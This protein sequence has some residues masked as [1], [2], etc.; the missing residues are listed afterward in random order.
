MTVIRVDSSALSTTF[1]QGC[2]THAECSNSIAYVLSQ[3]ELDQIKLDKE[4]NK[5]IDTRFE[6]II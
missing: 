2:L 6:D 5:D 3:E 4:L 1:V